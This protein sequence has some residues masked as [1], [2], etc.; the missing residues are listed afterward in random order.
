MLFVYA[1]VFAR[2]RPQVRVMM[3]AVENGFVELLTT[4]RILADA[5]LP[6]V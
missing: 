6:L 1:R 2:V 5:L 3:V 4:L